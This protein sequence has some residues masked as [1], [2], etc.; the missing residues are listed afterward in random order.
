VRQDSKA[1]KRWGL[2][3]VI[4][5]ALAAPA[6]GATL[7]KRAR[8][9]QGPSKETPLLGW[10]DEAA[11]VTIEGQRSGWYLVRTPEGQA[12]Y[13]WQE[14]LTFGPGEQAQVPMVPPGA[15]STTLPS[16]ATS[17]TVHT[18]T[19]TSSS[20]TVPVPPQ[21][22][23]PSPL[24]SPPPPAGSGVELER[25]RGEI[26]R[27]NA[28]QQDLVQRIERGGLHALPPP[29]STDGSTGA[30]LTFLTAGGFGGLLLGYLLWGWGRRDRRSRIRL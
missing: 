6:D 24:P 22:S 27:L 28:T 25:L 20:A 2:L 18:T 7:N 9:R 11:A 10:V 16:G 30:A 15:S 12:G 13:V 23:S 5:L 29:I 19:S 26:A 3:A 4:A 1:L 21:T 8:L 17:S 14:H